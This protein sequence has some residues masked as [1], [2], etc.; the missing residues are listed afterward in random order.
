MQ[1][2]LVLFS[3]SSSSSSSS[4]SSGSSSDSSEEDRKGKKRNKKQRHKKGKKKMRKSNC[5]RVGDNSTE[6]TS[7][8]SSD[9]ED[10]HFYANKK[11]FY[12]ANQYDFLEDKSKKF[13]IAFAGG[14]Y[15]EH[16]KIRKAA[17]YV[18]VN[19]RTWWSTLLLNKTAPVKWLKFKKLFISSWLTQ[20]YE[21]SSFK[22]I[23]FREQ[24][25][26]F[27]LGLP[28]EIRD[29]CLEQKSASIQ[30]LMSHA[31]RGFA[32]HSNSLTYPT[33][34]GMT[35][36]DNQI[37]GND[38]R[39]RKRYPEKKD[40]RTKLTPQE[41]ARLIKEGKC[42]G[43][44]E[45]GHI[46]AKC[47]KKASKEQKDKDEDRPES[48]RAAEA[49]GRRGKMKTGLVPDCVG[50]DPNTMDESTELCRAWGKVKDQEA[51]I[52]FDEGAKANFISPELA[53]RL[54]ITPDRM[55][56][57]VEAVLAAPGR[58]VAITPVIGKLRLHCQGYL[59]HED[60]L[61]NAFGRRFVRKFAEIAS[62]LHML[63][64]KG[65]PFS[66]GVTDV[67]AFQTLKDKMTTGPV[68]ILPDLQK[69]FEVYC[70]ACGRS[71]GAVLMQE[72][73]VIA[74]ESRMF[75]KPEMTAQI[76]EKELLAVIHVL[77][78][79]WH[80]LL[81]ADFTVF[82]DHQSLR[83]FLSQKQLSEKQMRWF[84]FQIVHLQ[85]QKNVVADALSRKPLVQAIS[86]IHHSSFEDMVDQY[87][88]DTDFADIFTRI[89]DGETVAGYSLREGYLMRK[90]ML[91]L[92][93][94][95]AK[96]R[97]TLQKSQEQQKKAAD[98]HRRDLKLTE[99]D[100]VL[101]C[102]EKARLRKK[103]GKERLF[104]KLSMRY[105]G[106]FQ[107]TERINDI[108][109][110]L[111]LPDTWK[112]HNAFHV[113]LLKP[114]RGD[115][116]DDGEPD[117]QPEVEE[118]EE[119]LVSDQILAHKDTKTKGVI[120]GDYN[121]F[122]RGDICERQKELV[123]L[124][125]HMILVT[126]DFE[127]KVRHPHSFVLLATSEFK[128]DCEALVPVSYIILNDSLYT[129]LCLQFKPQ[130]IAVSAL[131]L[132]AKLLKY[133]FPFKNW[134]KQFNATQF[135]LKEICDQ[136]LELYERERIST[137]VV[138]S[139]S[140][141]SSVD[142]KSNFLTDCPPLIAANNL[143]SHGTPKEQPMYNS[144]AFTN[145]SSHTRIT[146]NKSSLAKRPPMSMATNRPKLGF[147]DI[148][149]V[150]AKDVE[151]PY[152]EPEAPSRKKRPPEENAD[153]QH[154]SRQKLAATPK[155]GSKGVPTRSK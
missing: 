15:S 152:R 69:S 150:S 14:R 112:I 5:R 94:A 3:F 135:Q 130:H 103:K 110:Q 9:F 71:L 45:P 36:Q 78:Q 123:L 46:S 105:Y 77:T 138:Q 132:A 88:T 113:S 96:V 4:S 142:D 143:Q 42:F 118:N 72:G 54:K 136:I 154:T 133:N 100:W 146:S 12:K 115:V 107:I 86:A 80:Y 75:S 126:L 26:R 28:T 38:S 39:K 1:K 91:D 6:D 102:F 37:S 148:P 2:F 109:F 17:S 76:Y 30:E 53:A 87:A 144:G 99:N 97:E 60:F 16:S 95:F 24:I 104:P 21:P 83:Y 48:S 139:G 31:K 52:F 101:L 73:R 147:K 68:L 74:Y 47:P 114:F 85:G 134:W 20:E 79:W 49:R 59:G 122:K 141:S 82:T 92:D 127:L 61:H 64:Q 119:I 57:P 137:S 106:P 19:A 11:S 23:S 131:L 18:K 129:T 58:D 13:D 84:H 34:E 90:T 93:T 33:D 120:E 111:R 55:G 81:G 62:P 66:W 125:E 153:L 32:I 56:P 151:L 116:L 50:I 8:D 63:T 145:N 98:R 155:K 124:A 7:T 65:V 25:E 29:H 44:G 22:K 128:F 117:E 89:Q 27:T 43:C 35:Q 140:S 41:R 67:T 10:G 51:L 121:V 70:D 149:K 40:A 108:S